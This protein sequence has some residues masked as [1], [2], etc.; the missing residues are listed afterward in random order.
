M[1]RVKAGTRGQSIERSRRFRKMF[2]LIPKKN[3]KTSLV[4]GLGPLL[5]F[6]DREPSRDRRRGS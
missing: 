5:L 1:A 6:V 3:G 4:A 2:L